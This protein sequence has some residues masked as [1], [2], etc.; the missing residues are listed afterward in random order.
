MKVLSRR[1]RISEGKTLFLDVESHF[2]KPLD[3]LSGFIHPSQP[4]NIVLTTGAY[5]LDLGAF[6]LLEL[7]D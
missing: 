4:N 7:E 3:L 1:V 5:V 2:L 6:H